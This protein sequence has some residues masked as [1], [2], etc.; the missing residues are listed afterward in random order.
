MPQSSERELLSCLASLAPSPLPRG[1][2]IVWTWHAETAGDA[3]EEHPRAPL[4]SSAW[5]D[6]SLWLAVLHCCWFQIQESAL[7]QYE[8]LESLT[9]K[10]DALNP[11]LKGA[12]MSAIEGLRA[13]I[14]P[15]GAPV[16]VSG[17]LDPGPCVSLGLF[18]RRRKSVL[19]SCIACMAFSV[20]T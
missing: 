10:L 9:Q 1:A 16:L 8:K 19:H 15:H 11:E 7:Q 3:L 14:A 6:P 20:H 13:Q 18:P 5:G 12:A 2:C 4:Q 17:P